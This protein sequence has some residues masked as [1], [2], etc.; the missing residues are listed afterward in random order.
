VDGHEVSREDDAL[1]LDVADRGYVLSH[2]RIVLENDARHL[3]ANK[4]LLIA[5][6]LGER[7]QDAAGEGGEP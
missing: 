4:Q 3:R 7:V 5:S 6:Y 1:A 2:G